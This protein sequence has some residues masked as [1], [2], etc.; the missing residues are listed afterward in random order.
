MEEQ[1][2][3]QAEPR[4]YMCGA[5]GDPPGR[6]FRAQALDPMPRSSGSRC[7]QM[8]ERHL[9]D[10]KRS[11]VSLRMGT[12]SSRKRKELRKPK[13]IR[14]PTLWQNQGMQGVFNSAF[15]CPPAPGNCRNEKQ[16]REQPWKGSA[17]FS[18]TEFQTLKV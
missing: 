9:R 16:G 4:S 7:Q 5:A 10:H 17:C 2:V 14:T 15:P 18:K 3:H 12:P 13:L 6:Q 8:R 1:I 11:S